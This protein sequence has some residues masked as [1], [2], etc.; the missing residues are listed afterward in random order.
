M[1]VDV[2][3]CEKQQ[4]IFYD[5]ID[6]NI[7]ICNEINAKVQKIKKEMQKVDPDLVTIASFDNQHQVEAYRLLKRAQVRIKLL[8]SIVKITGMI[9]AVAGFVAYIIQVVI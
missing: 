5:M 8:G 6:N 2:E 4:E 9:N 7:K 1:A 3:T